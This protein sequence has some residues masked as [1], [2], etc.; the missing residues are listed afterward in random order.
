MRRRDSSYRAW[1]LPSARCGRLVRTSIAVS[2]VAS[3]G[4][5]AC[6]ATAISYRAA[7]VTDLVVTDNCGVAAGLYAVGVTQDARAAT[8]ESACS[9]F[10]LPALAN[11]I[12]KCPA[13][14]DAPVSMGPGEY[15]EAY[16]PEKIVIW[17][18]MCGDATVHS[19]YGVQENVW[20]KGTMM[21]T[22]KID[23]KG[24]GVDGDLVVQGTMTDGAT[25]EVGGGVQNLKVEA[26]MSGN[27]K[28][29]VSGVS[30]GITVA[31]MSGNAKIE[32]GSCD[33]PTTKTGTITGSA[34]ITGTG[35]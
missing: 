35:C 6:A 33:K 27:A 19:M 13:V 32:A 20:V 9:P 21:D 2:V 16:N 3:F 11:T 29:T 18:A 7:G 12:G 31:S 17:G 28:I 26:E 25:I 8:A 5:G 30:G 14:P 34:A 22:A 23:I 4:L 1:K 24:T 15:R 10:I